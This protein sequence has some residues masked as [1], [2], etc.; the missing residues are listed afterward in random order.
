M[1]SYI[2]AAGGRSDVTHFGS[3]SQVKAEFR[4]LLTKLN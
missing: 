4:G 3:D 1:H 2:Q